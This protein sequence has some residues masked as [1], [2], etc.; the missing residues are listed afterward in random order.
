MPTP[1]HPLPPA[2]AS[3]PPGDSFA[4]DITD[5]AYGGEGIGRRQGLVVFVPLVIPGERVVVAP[6]QRAARYARGRV[7]ERLTDSP[8]R[9]DPPCP[10]FGVCGGCQY[11][12]LAYPAQLQAKRKQIADILERIGGLRGAEVEPMEPSPAPAGYR[13]KITLHGPGRPGFQAAGGRGSIPIDRCL[14]A[15]DALNAALPDALAAPLQGRDRL[16]LRAA[17]GGSVCRYLERPGCGGAGPDEWLT[18]T[19]AGLDLRVP[20]RAFFQVN[21]A[22]LERLLGRL[23]A[24]LAKAGCS[25]LID[26]YCGVGVFALGLARRFE[27]CLGI[28][29]QALAAAAARENA[30]RLGLEACRFYPGL[31]ERLLPD[32][33]R[34]SSP[35]RTCVLLDPPRAGCAPRVLQAL[36]RARPR[37]VVY[38][39]CVPPVLARDLKALLAAG[40]R[41]ERAIP[42]DMFPQ[43]AHGEVLAILSQ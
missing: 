5:L 30:R 39:S 43:T 7:L 38:L 18:E 11:Q 14:L 22:V 19:I 27:R 12:H 20:A 26:A 3:A 34:T 41:L 35:G 13:N 37:C 6:E 23:E 33:L 29:S 31:T 10:W 2:G 16:V 25:T 42:F 15:E 36:A 17:S 8:D 24:V 1:S 9:R 21:R 40:Y 28:E 4:L 32:L